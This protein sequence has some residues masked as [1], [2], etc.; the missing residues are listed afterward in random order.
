MA[1]IG[2][3]SDLHFVPGSTEQGRIFEALLVALE[4]ERAARGRFDLCVITGD[5]F[6]DAGLDPVTATRAFAKLHDDIIAAMG[7]GVPS[8]IVPGNHDRRRL[9]LFGPHRHDL[10]AELRGALM[11]RAWVH[12]CALPFLADVIPPEEHGLPL[13][14]VAYDSTFLTRGLMS[15]G[16]MI[17]Q[18]DLLQAAAVIGAREPDWPVVL[19]LH[20]HLVPTP[21]TD[22]TPIDA[23]GQSLAA[24]FGLERVLPWLFSH[25]DR[26]E[27]TMTALGAGTA[28]STLHTLGRAVLVLHGHKHYAT[29]RL[30]D[31]TIRG[32]GDVL[33]VSAGSAGV[34]QP[35]VPVR[36]RESARLWPS[37]NVLELDRDR[38]TADTVSFG[39]K[40][41]SAGRPQRRPLVR[42]SR[43][44]AQWLGE[45]VDPHAH[46][47]GEPRLSENHVRYRLTATPGDG[48]RWSYTCDRRVTLSPGVQLKD[49]AET[50]IGELGAELVVLEGAKEAPGRHPLPM[51]LHLGLEA[52][53]RFRVIGGLVRALNGLHHSDADKHAPFASLAL[54]NRYPCRA[55]ELV[56]E[57]LGQAAHT[58]FATATDLGMG[59]EQPLP[60]RVD[61]ERRVVVTMADCPPRTLLSVYWP[62]LAGPAG[63]RRTRVYPLPTP[64][65]AR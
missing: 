24:R 64:A 31:A 40:G 8:V 29:A 36:D 41:R 6:D 44:R 30:L 52:T 5:V 4:R 35:W 27:L 43:S 38:L 23:T 3:L 54:M 9:G 46:D 63:Q 10:F 20:H 15:A 19:L 37:F 21:I 7:G 61:E 65:H 12:G 32:H 11:G 57:G 14:L 1:R 59:L 45:P 60:C 2:Q 58:A 39:Y 25:A 55:S 22:L 33:I 48:T 51:L 62:L 34:A 49:Y 50:V 18:Q 28:I 17:R 26:E 13:W 56:V 47:A 16:G 42:A 53:T